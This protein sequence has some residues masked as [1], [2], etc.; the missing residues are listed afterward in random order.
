M[1][2]EIQGMEEIAFEVHRA[3]VDE[4]DVRVLSLPDGEKF[5]L[6]PVLA[7]VDAQKSTTFTI[8][9]VGTF[10]EKHLTASMP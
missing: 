9:L 3:F 4:R 10:T 6:V 8:L 1:A 2:P 7:G 5:R